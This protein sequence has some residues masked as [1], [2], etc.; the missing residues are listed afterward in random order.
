LTIPLAGATT[1]G[2]LD[3]PADA[4]ACYVF[5]HGAGAGMNHAFMTAM[6]DGLARRGIATLRF[7]FPYMEQGSKRPDAP[8]VA[9]AAVRAAALEAARQLPGLPL[10]AGGKSYG[11]RMTSQAQ[12]A[13]PLPGVRGIVFVG[14]PLHPAGKPS[15]ERARHLAEVALP[16][17]FLQGT[18]DELAEL[19]LI[20]Q[21]IDTL[22]DRATLHVADGADHSFHVLVRSGRTDAQVRLELL[23]TM[24]RWIDGLA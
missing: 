16:M 17:L 24:A 22:D 20:R 21:T 4:R 5:A 13:Q 23:D 10:F 15:V 6:A 18:R 12:A 8:A 1:S 11:G 2:L 7:Q 14:F 9:Q 19:E 3:V